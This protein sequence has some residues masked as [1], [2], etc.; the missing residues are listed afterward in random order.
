MGGD[1]GVSAGAVQGEFVIDT[2]CVCVGV[3]ECVA[4]GDACG[5]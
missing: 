5:F 2:A 1:S 3:A 4:R